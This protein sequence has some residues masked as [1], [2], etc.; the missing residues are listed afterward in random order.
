VASS[1]APN[2]PLLENDELTWDDGTAYPENCLD[3]FNLVTP[4][5]ALGMLLVGLGGFAALGYALTI[6]DK[7]SQAPY[8]M[9]K[10]MD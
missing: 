7:A 6:R 1:K 2:E 5:G 4:N 10:V 8:V 9:R 3:E